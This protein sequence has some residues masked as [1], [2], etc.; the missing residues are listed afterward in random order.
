MVATPGTEIEPSLALITAVRILDWGR[1]V[2]VEGVDDPVTRNDFQ[3]DF[4][5]C[6]ELRWSLY[7][8]APVDDAEADVI[9]I[10]LGRDHHREPAVVT[11]DLFE[12]SIRYGSVETRRVISAPE[13]F[14]PL[15]AR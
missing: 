5:D 13:T 15:T 7:E 9:G 8:D 3:I 2:I 1:R 14:E 6:R 11:T 12:L 4:G 10:C